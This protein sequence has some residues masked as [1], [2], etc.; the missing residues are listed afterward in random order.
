MHRGRLTDKL[1]AAIAADGD[2]LLARALLGSDS[3]EAIEGLL[4]EFARHELGAAIDELEFCE[5]SVGAV[6]GLR[7]ADER[8][9]VVKVFRPGTDSAVVD[10]LVAVQQ[11]LA[12]D[13][14][15]CPNVLG[16]RRSFGASHAIVMPLLDEG[17]YVDA[18]APAVRAEWAALLQR[19]IERCRVFAD[20]PGFSTWRP[21]SG[22]LWHEPHNAL[23]DFERT[24]RG[25][26]WIDAIAADAL[27]VLERQPRPLLLGHADWSAKHFRYAP[28][29][30]PGRRITM[31][32][33]WDSLRYGTEV[34]IVAGAAVSFT[35]TWYV[36][37]GDKLPPVE[38]SLA[39]VADYEA[40]RGA[41]FSAGERHALVAA[42]RYARAYTAR[43]EHSANSNGT[44]AEKARPTL[45]DVVDRF[46]L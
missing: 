24:Q 3:L 43:C 7:L 25:A 9:V 12:A 2:R 10:G 21:P 8:R 37:G 33:D 16:A 15:P 13:G 5:L 1:A 32:Y 23:F 46:E 30:P 29:R 26:E 34:E 6:F 40:A 17:E 44:S 45:R 38:S 19:Q 18:K 20:S 14:F 42:A 4:R 28:Q 27:A 36:P 39:F 31:V 22:R 11:H 35:V 41:P